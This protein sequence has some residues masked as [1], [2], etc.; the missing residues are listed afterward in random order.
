MACNSIFYEHYFRL[1]CLLVGAF[2]FGTV[3]KFVHC[4][5]QKWKMHWTLI[6]ELRNVY[7]SIQKWKM[8]WMLICELR[9]ISFLLIQFKKLELICVYTSYILILML[10]LVNRIQHFI[11]F[12]FLF[13]HCSPLSQYNMKCD[14]II[15]LSQF[16][17]VCIFVTMWSPVH[18]TCII[19]MGKKYYTLSQS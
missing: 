15:I 12:Y 5:I 16:L 2:I 3:A 17:L 19:L 4:S 6:C 14:K 8:H 18:Y 7:F 13:W 9:N 11:K 10:T 1:S